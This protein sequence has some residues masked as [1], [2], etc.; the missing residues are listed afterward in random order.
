MSSGKPVGTVA[1]RN[2]AAQHRADRAMHIADRKLQ[3]DGLAIL[4]RGLAAV[5]QIW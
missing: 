2:F 5:D 1:P 3:I 4:Q